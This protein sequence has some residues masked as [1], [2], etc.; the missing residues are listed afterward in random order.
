[1]SKNLIFLILFTFAGSLYAQLSPGDLSNSHKNLEGLDRC[2]KCHDAGKKVSAAKCLSCHTILKER[3]ESGKGLHKNP[4]FRR[5]ESC[6]VEHL[7]RD[8]KLIFWKGGK[9][10]F[11]HEETGYWLKGKHRELDC[12]SCH[13]AELIMDKNKLRLQGKDLE[14]TFLGL[15]TDCLSCHRDEHRRQLGRDCSSCHDMDHWKPAAGFNHNQANFAL[16]GLHRDVACEK[17]HTIVT[18]HAFKDDDS[19]VKFKGIRFARC[20][21]CHNDAH[22][23]KFGMNCNSCH[24]TGG[25][26]KLNRS[27]FDHNLTNFPLKGRHATL[28]CQQCHLEGQPKKGV[29]HANCSDCHQDYH[30]GQF[31]GRSGGDQCENCHTERGFLPANYTINQHNLSKFPLDGAHL[32]VPCNTC[33]SEAIVAGGYRT[34]R[35]QFQTL[36]C[37][38]C[39]RDPHSGDTIKISANDGCKFCHNTNTWKSVN[40][41]HTITGF[42]LKGKHASTACTKCHKPNIKGADQAAIRFAASSPLCK[43]CHSDVHAGQFAATPPGTKEKVSVCSKCHTFLD[44][45]PVKFDHNRDAAFSLEGAHQFVPCEKCHKIEFENGTKFVRYK[46]IKANCRDCHGN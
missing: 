1:M 43:D 29:R 46:P 39:H 7:G 13:K 21:D 16:T 36:E 4:K 15:N 42:R 31:S 27:R 11:R 9:K 40:F 14:R 8:Y 38:A 41:D 23:G 34:R 12:N 5:C 37:Q 24:T 18:D 19:Y 28:R 25:W 44:W 3:I 20:S 30:R 22:G 32:A 45:R 26:Q 6:H 17:C 2:T 10:S 35:F 33:H